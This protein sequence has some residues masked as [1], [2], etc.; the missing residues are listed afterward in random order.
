MIKPVNY[1][2]W[3]IGSRLRNGHFKVRR[4]VWGL[5]LARVE[6]R[7]DEEVRAAEIE[8]E[9]DWKPRHPKPRPRR[10]QLVGSGGGESHGSPQ[11]DGGQDSPALLL[12]SNYVRG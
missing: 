7:P 9:R 10:R 12:P 8:V 2:A 6:R 11:G 1:Q 3:A 5:T 4:V